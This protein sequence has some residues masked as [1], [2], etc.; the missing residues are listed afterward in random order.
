MT[1]LERARRMK[2]LTQRELAEQ[3]EVPRKSIQYIESG[4]TRTPHPNTLRKL[5]SVLEVDPVTLNP[6]LESEPQEAAVG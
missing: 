3:A 6:A 4:R 2:L 5:A 1:G